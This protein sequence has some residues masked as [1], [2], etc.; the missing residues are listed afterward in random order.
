MSVIKYLPT[1]K[2]IEPENLYGLTMGYVVAQTPA[3]LT[4]VPTVKINEGTEDEVVFIENGILCAL[5]STGKKIIAAT[6]K[7]RQLFIHFTEELNTVIEGRKYFALEVQDGE[8][9]PRL[10]A[11]LPG[12]VWTTNQVYNATVLTNAGIVSID[13]DAVLPDGR[14][15]KTYMYVG[16]VDA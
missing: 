3:D 9:Y 16:K 1:F 15:A 5:D 13:D 11:L 4:S 7:E 2:Q 12:S 8:A 14:A 6:G 10:V